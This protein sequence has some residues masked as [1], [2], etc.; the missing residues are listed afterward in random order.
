MWLACGNPVPL[1]L[2]L[3]SD[4]VLNDWVLQRVVLGPGDAEALI[5][6]EQLQHCD[7]AFVQPETLALLSTRFPGIDGQ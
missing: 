6:Y 3:V 2:E 4:K 7:Q 1:F 5:L